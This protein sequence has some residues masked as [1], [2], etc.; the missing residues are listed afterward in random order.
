MACGGALT[1]P[2][3]TREVRK[4]VTVVF[5]DVTGST[6]L[7]EQ[8]DPESLR[9]IM[10]RWFEAMRAVL[11][12]HGGTVEKFI[13]DAVVA[14]Y[15]VPVLHEDDALRAVRA[16]AEMRTALADLNDALRQERG[17]EIAMRVGVNTGEVVV[18]DARAGGGRATGDAVNVAARLQQS[19]EPGEV[20]LGESTW[21]LVRGAVVT[22]DPTELAVRGRDGP[23]GA[24]RLVDV[25]RSAE[26][27]SRRVGGRMIGRDREIGVLRGALERSV[28]Q[29]ACVLVTVLGSPGVGK[30]RLTHEFL[31]GAR[32]RALVLRGRCL[33]YGEGITWWP[34]AE[35][36]RSAVGLPAEAD[37]AVV[38]AG[39]RE[40]LAGAAS[41]E[42]ILARV[43]E[44]LGI[45]AE[46]APRDEL[47][48]A[49]RR[50]FE[51][52]A[53]TRPLVVVLGDL[54]WAEPSLLDL[55]EHVAEWAH[56][57]PILLLAMARPELLDSRPGW[58]GGM[59]NATTFLL[60]PLATAE[61]EAMVDTLLEGVSLPEAARA[62]IAAAADG[63]PLYVE[64]VVEMLLDDGAVRRQVD[65][66]MAI[67]DLDAISVPP[68]IQALLAARL[69]R[70]GDA[71]RLTIERASVV[72]KEFGRLDVAELTPETGR[73]GVSAQLMA[74]VR[75][76]LIRPDRRRD[77]TDDTFRFRHLLIRD[78]AY[79]SLPKS[80][81]AALHERF[82][83]WLERTAGDRLAELDEIMG[84]HLDQART[85]R[86][87]LG[88]EDERSRVLALRAGRHLAAAGRRADDR[89]E[90]ASAVRLL[91]RAEALLADEPAARFDALIRLADCRF[92]TE[93]YG[94]AMEAARI[95]RAVAPAIGDLA[96]HRAGLW[97]ASAR[98]M[99]DPGYRVSDAGDDLEAAVAAFEDAGD[100][101]GLLD[102]DALRQHIHLNL[103]HWSEAA[104]ASRTGWARAVA[105]GRDRQR[106][107]F[108]LWLANA[109]VWGSTPVADGL[110]TID[111]LL[112][113][114]T[115]RSVLG[116]LYACAAQLCAY[117][118]DRA[119]VDA[120]WN[121]LTTIY[122]ELG[123]P[124]AFADFRRTEIERA[125][126]DFSSALPVA[127]R[128]E[129]RLA[130]TGET[131]MRSTVV[132][133]AGWICLQSGDDAEAWRLAEECR[134]LAADD[135]AVSQILRRA[136]A[137]VVLARRGETG[138][139]DRVSLEG[140][141]MATSTDSGVIGEAWLARAEV[142]TL[143][144][145]RP[146]A[147]QAAEQA[148]AAYAAKGFVNGVRWAEAART[149]AAAVSSSR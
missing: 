124:M 2:E 91:A 130:T 46:P 85:Y 32:E 13:G 132:V 96:V 111:E 28:A 70:L 80:E 6:H 61:T 47:V 144:G 50:L 116:A 19:A 134:R 125:L 145:R 74:L 25:D 121:S 95:S 97:V 16:A 53:S 127:R 39:L 10:G 71:E 100:V 105:H 59:P 48:W 117:A 82:A 113:T 64:Q 40:I 1:A 15:G 27:I 112:R 17:L 148:R 104:A 38:L 37:P 55:V 34:V 114:T 12:R 18:G 78:A 102:A 128:L 93:D 126:G 103:A 7:G 30:S 73:D 22:G 4:V 107:R 122:E 83:D 138:D 72:G 118:D 94:G 62:R 54:Q 87:A 119:G 131:G 42:T 129:A 106:D 3:P 33:P 5:A 51:R 58:G 49:I 98:S 14:V 147:L 8:L 45:A 26:A 20:L 84:Y 81:R 41:A 137:S 79:E 35:L 76:E 9:A 108:A 123:R 31:A 75:K 60:E 146:E 110:T 133:L 63:N 23:V 90:F 57:V 44:P 69:D 143:A 86:L 135:D 89:E 36:L 43:A 140:T 67:G 141:E 77:E 88:P 29:D 101:D 65:G 120:A 99:V 149:A 115:R 109:V 68:T 24:R 139:A 136:V 142:L 92:S 52:L 56:G 21:R 66:S 11:E